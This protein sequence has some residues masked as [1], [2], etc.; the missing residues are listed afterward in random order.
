MVILLFESELNTSFRKVFSRAWG[1]ATVRKEN[2]MERDDGPN[3]GSVPP[4]PA[5]LPEIPGGSGSWC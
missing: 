5:F 2:L 1:Q 4:T 3:R